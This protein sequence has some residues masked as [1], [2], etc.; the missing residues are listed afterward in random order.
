MTNP[1][2]VQSQDY[3]VKSPQIWFPDFEEMLEQREAHYRRLS[4]DFSSLIAV[5]RFLRGELSR[6]QFVS[7]FLE[8]EAPGKMVSS[9]RVLYN[10]A[11]EVCTAYENRQ[12]CDEEF[13]EKLL[14]AFRNR[15]TGD[16]FTPAPEAWEDVTRLISR[17][18]AKSDRLP[19]WF[20]GLG[21]VGYLKGIVTSRQ[22]AEVHLAQDTAGSLAQLLTYGADSVKESL[23]ETYS[24]EVSVCLQLKNLCCDYRQERISRDDFN[25]RLLL[26]AG[27]FC[28]DF[29]EQT[30]SARR[31]LPV[32][33]AVNNY[34]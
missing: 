19:V 14:L 17:L 15:P 24:R 32:I 26:L 11:Q 21:W 22:Y 5:V 3:F 23:Q 33:S 28:R 7:Q 25:A 18:E 2:S 20:D 13:D 12:I 9:H 30:K 16:V 6:A 29:P 10:C 31:M 34:I 8:Q 4:A 1:E 27:E